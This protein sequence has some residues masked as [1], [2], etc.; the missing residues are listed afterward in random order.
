MVSHSAEN[1]TLNLIRTLMIATQMKIFNAVIDGS[2][3][4]AFRRKH[5]GTSHFITSVR[6]LCWW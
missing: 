5:G 4:N 1:L 6:S 2:F 3:F